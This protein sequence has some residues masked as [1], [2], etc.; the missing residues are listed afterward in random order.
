MKKSELRKLSGM[1]DREEL[2]DKAMSE[3]ETA[4]EEAKVETYIHQEGDEEQVN[5]AL[6]EAKALIDVSL[7]K[8]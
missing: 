4:E 5:D 2:M 8:N 6:R 3:L 1:T 7:M